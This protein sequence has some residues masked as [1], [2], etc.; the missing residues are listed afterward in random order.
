MCV[1]LSAFVPASMQSA[2]VALWDGGIRTRNRSE[3]HTFYINSH[4]QTLLMQECVCVSVHVCL[5]CGWVKTSNWVVCVGVKMRKGKV[6][7]RW[8]ER[9]IV[10]HLLALPSCLLKAH[11][12]MRRQSCSAHI[13]ELFWTHVR[14]ILHAGTWTQGQSSIIPTLSETENCFFHFFGRKKKVATRDLKS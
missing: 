4:H 12:F 14:S 13:V 9:V 3:G 11:S 1:C 2:P 8:R 6:R 7:E 10:Q 5:L